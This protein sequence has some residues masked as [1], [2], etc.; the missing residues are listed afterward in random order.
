MFACRSRDAPW[1]IMLVIGALH[2]GPDAW[3]SRDFRLCLAMPRF[4]LGSFGAP[5]D[6]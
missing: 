3:I 4:T 1:S 6:R 5:E 2:I